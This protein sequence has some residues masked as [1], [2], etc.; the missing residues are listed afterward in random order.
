MS[1]D[2]FALMRPGSFSCNLQKGRSVLCGLADIETN[3]GQ[4]NRVQFVT[5]W[6]KLSEQCAGSGTNWPT[7][8]HTIP[9][10][11][12]WTNSEMVMSLDQQRLL[13]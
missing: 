7:V 10:V 11:L 8:H 12:V 6:A 9:Y 3:A 4:A 5:H 2:G 13:E 1:F